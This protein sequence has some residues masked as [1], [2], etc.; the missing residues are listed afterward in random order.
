V[1]QFQIELGQ[2]ETPL[3]LPAVQLLGGPEVCQ[4]FVIGEDGDRVLGAEQVMPPGFQGT[5][6]AKEFMI[7]DFVIPLGHVKGM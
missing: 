7:V 5:D 1:Y 3:C 2:E 6:D 4:V